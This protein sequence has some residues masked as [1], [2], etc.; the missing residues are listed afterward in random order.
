MATP[1][2]RLLEPKEL[3]T[4]LGREDLVIVDLCKP[5]LYARSHVPGALH[6]KGTQLMSNTPPALGI[7]PSFAEIE[8][9]LSYIGINPSKHVVIYD[10]EG[11]GWAGRLAW[12]LDLVGLHQWSYLNGGIV[13]W[14][15]EGHITQKETNLPN[16][17]DPQ[18]GSDF[19]NLSATI[20]ADQIINQLGCP[21]FAIWDARRLEEYTGEIT[22]A[23]RGGHIPGAINLEWIELIDQKNNLR[24]KQNAQ[25]IL[26]DCGLTK[27]KIIATHCQLHQRSSFTYM[28]ARILGYEKITGYGGSWA[29]WGNLDHT[30][31]EYGF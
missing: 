27:D 23:N 24:I 21:N 26:D 22:R 13:S 17:S 3:E 9:L 31:I 8:S 6:L 25:N 18:I 7:H 20:G 15:K 28:V 29:E 4:E 11:G 12:I 14:I 19:A 5:D 30:P 1:L 16:R 10:D 2:P